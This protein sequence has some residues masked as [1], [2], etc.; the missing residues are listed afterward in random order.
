MFKHFTCKIA[1]FLLVFFIFSFIGAEMA[2][3]ATVTFRYSAVNP[4]AAKTQKISIKKYL[5]GEV[6]PADIVDLGGLEIEYDESKSL[7]YVYKD[8]VELAPKEIRNFEVEVNDVW[9]VP[10]YELSELKGRTD[11]ILAH[12]EGTE[13]YAKAKEIAN[14]IYPRVEEIQKTQLDDTISRP[15]H[16]GVYRQ[17]LITMKEIKD[18]IASMEKILVTAGGPPA[19]E[20]LA[21]SKIKAEAPTKTMTWIV[22]F[23]IIIF[24]GLLGGVMFFTWHH[25]SRITKETLS[26]SR[27]A[28]FP[29][30]ERDKRDE[31]P[32]ES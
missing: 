24:L 27:N 17:N 29:S 32:P 1:L 20:M 16:I 13:F 14:T 30:A 21:E 31:T 7:Y 11:A 22:I 5:P 2:E 19:P 8:N 25:Q 3:A 12:L 4:S 6:T 18:D 9:M 26:A 15:R 28:A 23:V 10:D